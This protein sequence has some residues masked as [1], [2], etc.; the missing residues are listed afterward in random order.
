M[1]SGPHI[2]PLPAP[3][4]PPDDRQ[5]HAL[6]LR[7]K[8][9][10]SLAGYV[11][12][13]WWPRSR[14][15]TVELAALVKV[16]AVRLDGVTRVAF[17]TTEWKAAPR[18]IIVDGNTVQLEGFRSADEHL[19]HVSGPDRRR[20]TLLVIPPDAT[21]SASHGAMTRAARRDNTDEPLDIL[22]ATGA[23]PYTQP[24]LRL[25]RHDERG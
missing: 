7:L 24:P 23:T 6:R 17:A 10:G 15:L 5:A 19:V 1:T 22:T 4:T 21:T 12:G 3:T 25:V 18:R 16:L 13:A 20:I 11:D 2:R 14:D 9:K 8:P